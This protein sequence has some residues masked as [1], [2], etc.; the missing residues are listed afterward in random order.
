MLFSG[1]SRDLFE[2]SLDE[3]ADRWF[4]DMDMV[5]LSREPL[6]YRCDCSRERIERMLVTLGR[7]ELA[8]M[9]EKQHG[10]QVDC[11]FCNRRYEFSEDDLKTIL[12]A[13]TAAREDQ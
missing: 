4:R 9:I 2:D 5:K 10:A 11:H 8:D 6:S 1:I 3:L 7:D 13:A 12:A